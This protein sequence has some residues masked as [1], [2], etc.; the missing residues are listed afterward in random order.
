MLSRKV[1]LP[2]DKQRQRTEIFKKGMAFTE[3]VMKEKWNGFFLIK[4]FMRTTAESCLSV[5]ICSNC[6]PTRFIREHE[7][8]SYHFK[9]E[10]PNK[11]VLTYDDSMKFFTPILKENMKKL[12]LVDL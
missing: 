5:H 10:V 1:H 12:F 7:M 11:T 4:Y 6:S 2:L 9:I 8:Y 3:Y